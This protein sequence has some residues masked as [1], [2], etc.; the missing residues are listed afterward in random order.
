MKNS[1]KKAGEQITNEYLEKII[2][3]VNLYLTGKRTLDLYELQ[4]LHHI[5]DHV[6]GKNIHCDQTLKIIRT[7]KVRVKDHIEEKAKEAGVEPTLHK[8][9]NTPYLSIDYFMAEDIQTA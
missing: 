2:C 1:E 7:H 3:A 4:C 9:E 8:K 5:L 6:T